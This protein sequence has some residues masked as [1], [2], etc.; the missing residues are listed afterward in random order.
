MNA[1]Q[2]EWSDVQKAV[3]EGRAFID[4]GYGKHYIT[5]Y[6]RAGSVTFVENEYHSTVV[7]GT[8]RIGIDPSN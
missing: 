3:A 7:Y 8:G 5:E 4:S 6:T 1:S 2:L